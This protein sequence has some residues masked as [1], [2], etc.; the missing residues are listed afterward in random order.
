[1]RMTDQTHSASD[2]PTNI[3]SMTYSGTMLSEA[4]NLWTKITNF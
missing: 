3:I 2:I 1:M 4:A